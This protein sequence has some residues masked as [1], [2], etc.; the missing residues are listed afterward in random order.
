MGG[1]DTTIEAPEVPTAGENFRDAIEAFIE[2]QEDLRRIEFLDRVNELEQTRRLG[3]AFANLAL[4][5][6]REFGGPVRALESEAVRQTRAGDI[7]NVGS[8]SPALRQAQAIADPGSEVIRRNLESDITSQ[9]AAGASLDPELER[10][11][12]QDVRRG[13]SARGNLFGPAAVASEAAFLASQRE[14]FRQSRQQAAANFLQLQAATQLDPFTFITGRS[15]VRQAQPAVPPPQN[16]GTF[17]PA[18]LNN[19]QQSNLLQAQTQFNAQALGAGGGPSFGGAA[20]GALGG[21]ALGSAIPGIGTVVGSVLG[22][23]AGLFGR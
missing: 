19:A 8:L 5:F 10:E 18:L 6:E 1:S 3:P 20:S 14:Q 16:V 13:Q 7:F 12:Q 4:N 15:G 11:F 17:L 23:A 2:N 22:G 21:A 9:L